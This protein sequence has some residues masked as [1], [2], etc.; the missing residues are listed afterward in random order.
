MDD[1]DGSHDANLGS[2]QWNYDEKTFQV[3]LHGRLVGGRGEMMSVW[4]DD[5]VP[6]HLFLSP[7]EILRIRSLYGSSEKAF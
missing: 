6:C 5:H 3:V 4:T 1:C 2:A 7:D